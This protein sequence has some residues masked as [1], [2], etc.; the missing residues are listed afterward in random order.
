MAESAKKALTVK[1]VEAA[2]PGK[3]YDGTGR[4]G[5]QLIVS[6]A[7]SKWWI[8]RLVIRGERVDLGLGSAQF[9]SLGEAR[10]KAFENKRIAR[11]GGDPRTLPMAPAEVMTF[12]KAAA[13]YLKKKLR[14]LDNAKHRAQWQSSLEQY[15]FPIIGKT[16]VS[17]VEIQDVLR[18]LNPIWENKTQTASRVR[19][20]M[21]SVLAWATASGHRTGENPARWKKN[22]DSILSE[23][24]KIA[25]KDNWPAVQ[26]DLA[27]QW[28]ADLRKR[29]GFAA[30]ALELATLCASRSGEVR[31]AKWDEVDL[32]RALW[33][34]P[35]SRM[36]A[37]REH[38]VAL[39][40]AAVAL[41][42]RLPRLAGTELV[43]PAARGSALSDMSLSAVMRRI[44]EARV[45]L[46]VTRGVDPSKAGYR[47]SRSGRPSVPHGVRSTFR[48]WLGERTNH[49]RE[50]G[51]IALAHSVGTEVERAYARSD[52]IEKRRQVMTEWAK[53]LGC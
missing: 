6:K 30:R 47:D 14:E 19:G 25:K 28:F 37:D 4:L 21:E 42:K 29:E 50:L 2:A 22:L 34:I 43:F 39:S 10:A 40:P 24:G 32:D 44:H 49:P 46:D 41:L 33:T 5:L 35:A 16:P 45:V 20:R 27:Q 13:E 8:Q 26:L 23:P 48:D 1:K 18:V 3:H 52:Q 12:E 31:G 53:F 38:R 11:S 17:E 15:V 7:G 36:K 51:E 9:V